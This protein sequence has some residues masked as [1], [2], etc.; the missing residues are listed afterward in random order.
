[1]PTTPISEVIQRLRSVLLPEGADLT[2]GQLLECF[3][4]RRD[5]AALEALVRR[6]AR[7]VWG[8]CR[9]V[10]HHHHDAED[11][12]QAAF[13]VLARKAASIRAPAQLGNWLY[14]VAHRT[15]LKA[16]ATRARRQGRERPVTDVPEPAVTDQGL[17]NDLRPLLDRELSRLPEKYRTVLVLCELEGKTGREAARQLD[18]PQGTVASRLARARA[19]LARRLGRH[20]LVVSGGVLAAVLSPGL[21]SAGVPTAVLSSTI[22]AV[23]AVA[24]GRAAAGVVSPN[25]AA[26]TE[27][28]IKAM[29]LTKLKSV[30]LVLLVAFA[31]V[32]SGG[33]LYRTR[34]AEP[35]QPA[36]QPVTPLTAVGQNAQAVK[37]PGEDRNQESKQPKRKGE[38]DSPK[39]R[40]P[41]GDGDESVRPS[42]PTAGRVKLVRQMYAKLPCDILGFVEPAKRIVVAQA[43]GRTSMLL[44]EDANNKKLAIHLLNKL[45][46]PQESLLLATGRLPP[47]GPEESAVYGLLLRLAAK[48]PDRTT[49]GQREL[50]DTMLAVLDQRFA[51]AM[52]VAAPGGKE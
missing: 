37:R 16:R 39:G 22:K 50:L 21:A 26:L 44:L 46:E 32:G 33:A 23:T 51:G 31:V 12:F 25:V 48:P 7:M 52:P 20:G 17:W 6:H 35:G 43:D 42:K 38:G 10:L 27:G 9:R 19:M 40:T 34:A 4:S 45:S 2:D 24:A 11:A 5:G 14:G 36:A 8:V 13:L 1:M 18:L 41:R 29:A 49:E 15:A 30:L 3:V 47:R 28:V